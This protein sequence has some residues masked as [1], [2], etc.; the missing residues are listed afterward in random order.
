METAFLS[1][2]QELIVM[3]LLKVVSPAAQTVFLAPTP[4]HVPVALPDTS[5]TLGSV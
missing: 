2:H 5:S 3:L 1:V 4:S